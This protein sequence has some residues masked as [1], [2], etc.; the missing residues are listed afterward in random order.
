M[1]KLFLPYLTKCEIR[2]SVM[3]WG[4]NYFKAYWKLILVWNTNACLEWVALFLKGG[5]VIETSLGFSLWIA[6]FTFVGNEGIYSVGE[7]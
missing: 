6:S 4:Q 7:G 5:C 3:Q 1:A 2:V